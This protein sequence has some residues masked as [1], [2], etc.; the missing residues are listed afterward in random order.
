MELLNGF[1]TIFS[2]P[3]TMM[4]V[5]L[6]AVLGV[7]VGA[8]PGLTASAAIA[9]LVPITFYIDPLSALA[10]L[11]VIGKAGRFG[12]SISAILFN[13]PGTTAAA[14]TVIDGYPLTQKGQAGKALKTASL[15]SA[16]GDFFG[17][18]VLIFG[19]LTIA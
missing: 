13:T 7:V 16:L 10:F 2:Q 12:G 1:V 4:F 19:A 17:E 5:V 14:A 15:A 8:I 11:Y 3:V 6:G 18:L 9:M